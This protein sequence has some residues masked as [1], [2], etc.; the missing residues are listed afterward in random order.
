MKIISILL[1]FISLNA[2]AASK[3]LNIT[4]NIDVSHLYTNGINSVEFSPSV[5]DVTPSSDKSKFSDVITTLIIETEIPK[6]IVGI[7]YAINLVKN[8]SNCIDYSG[9]SSDHDDLVSLT[10]DTQ[11]IT[12]GTPISVANFNS[13]D[14]INKYSE[15]DVELIFKPFIDISTTSTLESCNGEIEFS[16]EVDI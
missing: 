3:P 7:S 15:H 12:A 10:F 13:D 6:D 11:P 5:L 14:G 4:T 2:N 16:V 8:S 1:V 9:S